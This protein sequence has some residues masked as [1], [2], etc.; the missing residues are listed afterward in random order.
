MV[1]DPGGAVKTV[2]L[3]LALT[4]SIPPLPWERTALPAPVPVV[5]VVVV[6]ASPDAP[7]A[8]PATHLLDKAKDENPLADDTSWQDWPAVAAASAATTAGLRPCSTSLK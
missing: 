7:E 5:V 1:G 6:V 4:S 2:V 8:D 3:V